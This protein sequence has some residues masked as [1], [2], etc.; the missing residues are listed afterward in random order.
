MSVI[1]DGVHATR[2]LWL[3][4]EFGMVLVPLSDSSTSFR[5]SSTGV[6]FLLDWNPIN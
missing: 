3:V 1:Y 2:L 4:D 6:V 5:V